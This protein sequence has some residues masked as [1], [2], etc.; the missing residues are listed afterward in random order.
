MKSDYNILC[1][2]LC[3]ILDICNS[4]G[5]IKTGIV[6]IKY[7]IA[8]TYFD[9]EMADFEKAGIMPGE[10][11]YKIYILPGGYESTQIVIDGCEQDLPNYCYIVD[12]EMI[13]PETY[14]RR[15]SEN[16]KYYDIPA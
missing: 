10:Y 2:D 5:L 8:F 14:A 3:N 13:V 11:E 1:T 6:K 15:D 12:N 9:Y 16:C 4:A 7:E